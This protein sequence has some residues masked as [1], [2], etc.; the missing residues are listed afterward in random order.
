MTHFVFVFLLTTYASL[1]SSRALVGTTNAGYSGTSRSTEASGSVALFESSSFRRLATSPSAAVTPGIYSTSPGPLTGSSN[2]VTLTL[3]GPSDTAS[4]LASGVSGDK[5]KIVAASD[6]CSGSAGG[7]SPATMDVTP[8]AS[9]GDADAADL[10]EVESTIVFTTAGTYKV[11]DSRCLLLFF[12]QNLNLLLT[13]LSLSLFL[14][15]LRDR[16]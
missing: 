5:V 10:T 6:D 13:S 8:I 7:G 9:V 11:R 4:G 16:R 14:G 12:L 15:V 2:T 1:A 3:G